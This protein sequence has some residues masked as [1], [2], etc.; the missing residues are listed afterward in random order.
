[1]TDDLILSIN[2]LRI[3]VAAA[4]LLSAH[5]DPSAAAELLTRAVSRRLADRAASLQAG[6]SRGAGLV[7]VRVTSAGGSLDA[8][9][10]RIADAVWEAIA[11]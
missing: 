11:P 2:R 10:D 4:D 9:A 3:R 8:L 1:M 7:K 6:D 5:S